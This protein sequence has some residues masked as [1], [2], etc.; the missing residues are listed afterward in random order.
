M[1][2]WMLPCFNKYLF[3]IDCPGCGMQRSIAFLASGDFI[4]AAKM[5]PA[6]YTSLIL[7]LLIGLH[8]LD[9]SRNYQRAIIVC[10]I[11]N[12]SI[13][14]ISYFYKMTNLIL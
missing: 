10:A 7:L 5:F 2:K 11:A 9:R 1:E 3:G 6:I 4:S 13:I 12:A 14:L 8:L